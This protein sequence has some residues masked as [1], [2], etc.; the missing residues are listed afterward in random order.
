MDSLS[1]GATIAQSGHDHLWHAKGLECLLVC[2]LLLS[3]SGSAFTVPPV[4]RSLPNRSGEFQSE[5]AQKSGDPLKTLAQLM[6][7][8]AETILELYAKVSNLDLGGSLQD[9]LRDSRVRLVNLLVCVKGG[10]GILNKQCLDQIVLGHSNLPEASSQPM[11]ELVAISR[12]GLANILIETLQASQSSHS[13]SHRTSLLVAVAS[14]LSALGLNRKHAFYIKQLMQQ[15][16]PKLLEA[17]RVGASEVG[18][19][20]AAGLPLLSHA[21][22]GIIPEMVVGTRTMLSLAAGAYGVPLAPVPPPRIRTPADLNDIHK[23]LRI[24]TSE[25]SSGD[26]LLKLEMLR[27]CVSVCEALPD[28][29]AGLHFTSNILRGAMQVVIMPKH[30]AGAVPLIPAEEQ[31]RLMDGM[32]RAVATASRLGADGCRAEYW[33]DFLVRE[34]K[35]F[36]SDL[37]GQL[38]AHKPSDLSMRGSGLVE[39]VRDPFIY[40]PFSTHKSLEA[41]PVLVAGEQA[42]FAVRLQNPLEVEVEIEEIRLIAEGCDFATFRH[43]VVLG[44]FS[45]QVFFL[46]GQPT[47]SGDLQIVGCRASVRDCYEQDFLIFQEDWSPILNTKQNA[48]GSVKFRRGQT[49]KGGERQQISEFPFSPPTTTPFNLK[50]ISAQPRLSFESKSLRNRAIMLLEGESRVFELTLV[51]ESTTVAADLVLITTEDSVTLGLQDALSNKDMNPTERYEIQNQLAVHP[52]VDIRD[53]Q[54]LTSDNPLRPGQAIVNR[55]EIFGR[56]GLVSAT[57]QADYA[58]LGSS[59][60]KVKGTFYTRQVRL[61]FAVTV[62]GSVEIPRCNLLQVHSDFVGNHGYRA[63]GHQ[64]LQGVEKAMKPGSSGIS[65][66]LQGLKTRPDASECCMLSLDLRNVWP[67]PLSIDIRARMSVSG[68]PPEDQAWEDAYSIRETL[69]PGHVNRVILL[70]PRLFIKNPHA[71]IPN[72]ETQKQF[73]VTTSK[74]SEEEEAAAR[75][76]FWY[77][78]ELLKCLQGTW[79]EESSGRHG[80]IN[81]RKGIRLSPRMV[82]VLKMDHV[83]VEYAITPCERDQEESESAANS[84]LKRIGRSHFALRT[85]SFATL[86]VIVHN[87]TQ[88]TLHLLLRLQPALR[89]QPHNIALDLS[90]RFAWSGVLQR[91]LH[92]AIE[93]GGSSVAELG[94]IALVHGDYEIDASVEEIKSPRTEAAA[95]STG[96]AGAGTE[97]RIWHARAPCCIDAVCR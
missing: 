87:R 32:R 64:E 29:P 5:A 7:P 59:S 54:S 65:K 80:E 94:I 21:L 90:K 67:Q 82:D 22:Q 84:A 77:R 92:P 58:C 91:A 73:V 56:P 24:W 41:A 61:P 55:V 74:L 62:N 95:K 6:P 93:P 12:V 11:G 17:R 23:K 72:L 14:S 88:E 50:V 38:I 43:S 34:V 27:A 20:P 9:V 26:A 60:S 48:V 42:T 44:P 10:G 96:A 30:P 36:E 15:F 45:T 25:H 83:D 97:R 31:A 76:S 85:E 47:E 49:A 40:N 78:E 75:E 57:V 33:D 81:L 70:V 53:H 51:N 63:S 39:A 8:M 13:L 66:L 86:S 69:Q 71:P 3:W 4:C 28:I 68:S 37:F 18:V 52:A 35:L 16:V 1:D 19:H 2:M 79:R 46:S 89:N